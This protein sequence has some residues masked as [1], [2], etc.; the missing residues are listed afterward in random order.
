MTNSRS[1][2][3]ENMLKRNAHIYTGKTVH[4][5]NSSCTMYNVQCAYYVVCSVQCTMYNVQCLMYI[6]DA[7]GEVH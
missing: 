1:G 2:K 3:M 4:Q 6:M 7:Y 5:F